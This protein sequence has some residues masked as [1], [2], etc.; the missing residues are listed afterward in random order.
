MQMQKRIGV[1][2]GVL[3]RYSASVA[4]FSTAEV[5]PPD[6][7][8]G[9]GEGICLKN[10]FEAVLRLTPINVSRARCWHVERCWSR[11]AWQAEK[12]RK[13]ESALLMWNV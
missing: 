12:E 9:V 11:W 7:S 8:T 10:T 5:V 2:E 13:R 6:Q 3:C 4:A 1:L